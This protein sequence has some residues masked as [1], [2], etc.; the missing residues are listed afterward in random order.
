MRLLDPETFV[1]QPYVA[2]LNQGGHVVAGAALVALISLL[3]WDI[4]LYFGA[5][6]LFLSFEAWQFFRRK[7]VGWDTVLDILFWALGAAIWAH[8]LERGSVSGAITFYPV[9][10]CIL[11]GVVMLIFHLFKPLSKED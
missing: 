6:V 9:W 4:G 11:M 7:A 5:A 2:G 3:P 1:D 10:L 8:G